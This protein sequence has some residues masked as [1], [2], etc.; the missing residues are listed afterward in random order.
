MPLV[1]IN[2]DDL[3]QIVIDK[4]ESFVNMGLWP[5]GEK[6]SPERWLQNFLPE[7]KEHALY[8][9]NAFTYYNMDIAISMLRSAIVKLSQKHS[10][11]GDSSTVLNHW[12][13]FLTNTIFVPVT[14][15]SPNI[16]DSGNLLAGHL[17]RELLVDE[18]QIF[19]LNQLFDPN[20]ESNLKTFDC[21]VFFD[22][23]VGSGQQFNTMWT[24]NYYA[25]GKMQISVKDQCAVLGLEAHYCGMIAT[26]YGIEN[27]VRESSEVN[28]NFAHILNQ[29]V[30]PLHPN[31]LAWPD[32][33][34][35]SGPD[36]VLNSSRRAGIPE[37]SLRG[38]HDLGLAIG[39]A[40]TIPDATLPIFRTKTNN[41]QP[42]IQRT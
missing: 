21:I 39:F 35:N 40:F 9:L 13:T 27:I 34:K 7:E 31:S 24:S 2:V 4:C 20:N 15:E 30:S 8:L 36:F 3:E 33:L 14:G 32:H 25:N 26:S 37:N 17:R 5:A 42:L 41:W 16:T 22:D 1:S 28:L 11:L 12:K 38:F 19:T 18:E 29:N 6:L 10:S 23:F